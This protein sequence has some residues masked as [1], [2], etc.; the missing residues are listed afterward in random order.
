MAIN[1]LIANNVVLGAAYPLGVLV[2]GVMADATSLR[3][4]TIGSGLVLGACALM[5]ASIR[6]RHTVPIA[7]LDATV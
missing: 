4:V 1:A 7:L 5:L 6:P 3:T 2:Q